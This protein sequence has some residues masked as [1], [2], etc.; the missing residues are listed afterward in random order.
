M[1]RDTEIARAVEPLTTALLLPLFFAFTGL[2]TSVQLISGTLLWFYCGVIIAVA[3][4]GKLFGC[5]FVLR[6][7]GLSWRESLSVGTLVNTRGL[8]ELVVLNI[9]LDRKIISPTLFSM[10]VLMTLVTTFM[11]SPLLTMINPAGHARE[12]S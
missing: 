4:F 1:P 12:S 6:A 9:G 8:I 2:R 7:R 3:I 11:T 10:M 5:A